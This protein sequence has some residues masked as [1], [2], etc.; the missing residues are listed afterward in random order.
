LITITL[1]CNDRNPEK[2]E[3][4][5]FVHELVGAQTK[6]CVVTNRT[7]MLLIKLPHLLSL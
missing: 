1:K 3:S 2:T 5:L 4:Q 7:T 6:F